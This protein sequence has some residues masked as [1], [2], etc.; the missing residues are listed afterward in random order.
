MQAI[1]PCLWFDT[2]AEEAAKFYCSIFPNSK[3]T[4][5]AK[6]GE[7]GMRPAGM[8]MIVEFELNGRP[9]SALNGGPQF[10]FSEAVSLQV[11]CDTQAEVD[12]YWTKL[13]EGGK[14]NVCGWLSD[15]YG[16]HWQIVPSVIRAAM[17]GPPEQT[18][19]V[20]QVVLNMIKPDIAELEKAARG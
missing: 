20:M 19:R 12:H 2:Q 16:F 14:P 15:R 3:I 1:A 8:V 6:Y 17:S 13:C 5:I 4:T 11:F 9:F 7:G 10:K 18:K